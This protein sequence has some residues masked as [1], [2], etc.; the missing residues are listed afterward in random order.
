MSTLAPPALQEP[1]TPYKPRKS[2]KSPALQSKVL[3]HRAIG[4]SKEKI[5][6]E[7]G[8]DK[9]TVTNILELHDF[10]NELT[11]NQAVSMKLIPEA[12]RV[13]H[14]RLAKDSE[15]MAIKVLENTIWP[16]NGKNK[17]AGMRGDLMVN[18]QNLI[19]PEQSTTPL[20]PIESAPV[21]V[22]TDAIDVTPSK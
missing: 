17:Q 18:I 8:I 9:R 7:L 2:I 10:D 6:K 5:A 19:Q 12:I 20:T 22:N 3:T 4:S 15:S 21:C 13:A 14:V 11:A 1:R 16:L